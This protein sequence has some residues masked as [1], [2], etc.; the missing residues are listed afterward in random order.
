MSKN[1]IISQMFDVR[2]VDEAGDLDWKKIQSVGVNNVGLS[3]NFLEEKIQAKR[4]REEKNQER[5]ILLEVEKKRLEDQQKAVLEKIN[6]LHKEKE[7]ILIAQKTEDQKKRQE[8]IRSQAIAHQE[9]LKKIADFNRERNQAYEQAAWADRKRR[10]EEEAQW[11]ENELRTD[12]LAQA[13][14]ELIAKKSAQSRKKEVSRS[15]WQDKEDDCKFSWREVFSPPH[16]AFQFDANKSL[17]TFAMVAF[18]ALL[19]LGS[20]AYASKGL[21]LRGKVLGVSSDGLAN[22]NAAIGDISHQ[23]FEGSGKQFDRAFANFSE[24][25]KQL[26]SMGGALLDVTRFVPFASKVSSGKNALEAGK[27]FSA[28]GKSLNEVAK[29]VSQLKNPN[30]KSEKNN[31]SLLDVLT[32]SQKNLIDA[33]KELDAAQKNID[34][35]SIDDLPEDKRGKFL[36][37]KQQLP[38]LLSAMDLFLNNSHILADLLGGNGPRKYL[39]L[40][41]N[42]SEMRATGGFIGSYGLL[43]IANGHIKNF[44]IDGIFNPDGQLKEKIVPPFPIQKISANWSMHDS[45]WFADFPISAKKAIYF[46]EK[47]GGPTADGVITLT[48]TV[49]QKLLEITGPI[50]MPEY[51]VTLD[52][53]NFIELTQF[54]VEVDYDKE[55]NKPKK[56]L[57]DLAPMVLE[58]LLSSNDFGVVS[59]TAQAFLEGLSEKHILFYSE[60]AELQK[61]ISKQGWSGEVIQTPKDYIS[62][63]NTNVN[64]YKT[65]AVVDESIKHTAQIQEDGS[66]IDTVTIT[67]KHTGGNSQ[68]EWLNK[69]NADYMRVYVPRG[70]KLLEVE[71]QTLETN[72][73]PLDYDALGFKRDIDVQNQEN[74]ILIDEK[75]GTR[76]Y[77][78][79]DKTV[80]ANWTYVSPQETMTITYEYLLPFS[81]FKVSIDEKQ[82]ADSYSLVAQK[83]SGS[84]GSN[85]VSKVSYPS[86][87]DVKWNF[88]AESSNNNGELKIETKLD[89][90]RFFGAVFE[91]K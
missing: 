42:N 83:Q 57:S 38:D 65:D 59:K 17:M 87:Y 13:E 25:S 32:I 12:A 80:F 5:A 63:I 45:N 61:I 64:G 51:E 74:S 8:R 60:N 16:F 21:G 48:P 4:D 69:V 40:F 55:E 19:G 81:L 11:L 84:V 44:F 53:E 22:L 79:S 10:E 29:V 7:A 56:I 1:R 68:Y 91:K 89:V 85:F 39:F 30:E 41:Q 27:H 28:A 6:K 75:S 82:Q 72:Q 77:E 15:K 71:G 23:N 3:A 35:I 62:V 66:I 90:D 2:P 58:K 43:D 49:M 36:L 14:R 67:R 18:V 78:E 46:Y 54:K 37:V 47:T 86:G 26:E 70:S 76:I 50:E 52:S 88:P 31:S 24:G 34:R 73:P 33:K 9:E 20:V